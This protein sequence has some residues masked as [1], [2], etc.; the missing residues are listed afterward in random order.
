M[1]EHDILAI[2][3]DHPQ[4]K[5]KDIS[6][7]VGADRKMINSTL[8]AHPELFAQDGEFRW[9]IKAVKVEFP[10]NTWVDGEAFEKSLKEAGCVLTCSCDFII[11]KIPQDCKILLE[12]VAR[13]LT[14]CNQ[15]IKAQ[16]TVTLDFTSCFR[17]LTFLNRI[18]FF[19]HLDRKVVILP[20][21]PKGST[22]DRYRGNSEAVVEFGAICIEN[23]DVSIPKLLKNQFIL[24][25][26]EKY[27]CAAFTIF[28]ELF[29]NVCEHSKSPIPGFAALQ[30]YSY[31][32][33]HIQT[34]VSDSGDG[35]IGTL[36]PVLE[37][38]YPKLAA[39]YDEDDP[40]SGVLLLKEVLENGRVT[41]S[42]CA[43]E[44]GRGL[45]LKKSQ[46]YAVKF[47][48]DISVRQETFELKLSYR[49]GKLFRWN[50]KIDMP[51]IRGTH[52]C[53]DFFLDSK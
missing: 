30:K 52:V 46:E 25:A 18:G 40:M 37:K 53:F 26:G 36:R 1:L 51:K 28:S 27:E 17:T 48:A 5:A 13:L 29:G 6:K 41:Q 15:L 38:H 31:P 4:L 35:I 19:D 10:E 9:S 34:V 7:K 8:Y 32:R 42:G 16:K 45:G 49:N 12:A 22:A 21:W 11:F 14:L 2:L 23:P 3:N 33:P 39:K 24:H 50:H 43:K 47:S 44:T 20:G